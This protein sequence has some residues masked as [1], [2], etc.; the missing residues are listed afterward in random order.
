MSWSDPWV[1]GFVTGSLAL[2]TAVLMGFITSSLTA[3][4]ARQDHIRASGTPGVPTVQE[5]WIRQDKM[6]RAFKAS[7]TLLGEVVEQHADPG[8]L[9]LS[10]AAIRTL[11]ESG[12]MPSELEDV[13]T[14]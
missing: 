14:D 4:R 9:K 10:K 2:I 6:E 7:L 1:P 8:S 13:L 5:I 11:R 12:Y 3:R